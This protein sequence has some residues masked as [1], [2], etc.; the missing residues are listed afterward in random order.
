[1]RIRLWR[2]ARSLIGIVRPVIVES[3]LVVS[4]AIAFFKMR[5]GWHSLGVLAM[6]VS[7]TDSHG[8]PED[9]QSVASQI[10]KAIA[11]WLSV[12]NLVNGI[13]HNTRCTGGLQSRHNHPDVRFVNNRVDVYPVGVR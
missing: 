2:G 11:L 6:A 7:L 5:I 1:M 9:G 10:E 13:F 4:R 12:D 8:H 3:N